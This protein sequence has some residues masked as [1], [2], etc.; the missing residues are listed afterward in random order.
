MKKWKFISRD[1]LIGS[2]TA[3]TIYVFYLLYFTS[4]NS[5]I[6]ASRSL[7]K[8][9]IDYVQNILIAFVVIYLL[10]YFVGF[11]CQIIFRKKK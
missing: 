8:I 10:I 4:D 3:S 6:L 5:N 1:R 7:L 2:F 9:A 11:F